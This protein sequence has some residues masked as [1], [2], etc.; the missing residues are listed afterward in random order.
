MRKWFIAVC[1]WFRPQFPHQMKL[2][3]NVL[4]L[5]KKKIKKNT[6]ILF[7]YEFTF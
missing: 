4:G 1:K 7:N 5:N 2:T 6:Q 3:G